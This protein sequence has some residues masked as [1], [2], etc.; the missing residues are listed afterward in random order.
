MGDVENEL[1]RLLTLADI[2]NE[3]SQFCWNHSHF[4]G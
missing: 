4:L 3:S 2:K 1:M